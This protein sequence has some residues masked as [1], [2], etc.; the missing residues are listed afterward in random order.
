[1][2]IGWTAGIG[3][4]GI[5]IKL[6]VHKHRPY[7]NHISA[8]VIHKECVA[9]QNSQSGKPSGVTQ[10]Q[11]GP[12]ILP[13]R[14]PVLIGIVRWDGHGPDPLFLQYTAGLDTECVHLL[15]DHMIDMRIGNTV[16]GRENLA[17]QFPGKD[18]HGPTIFID[19]RWTKA[20]R[21][22]KKSLL[23][24]NAAEICAQ[25]FK[26]LP[27]LSC[28]GQKIDPFSLSLKPSHEPLGLLCVPQLTVK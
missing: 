6:R 16:R 23:G 7:L 2:A 20:P 26:Q 21:S 10:R 27:D 15:G 17:G 9:S 12:A 8:F 1:L 28:S 18:D 14:F 25:I 22:L 11:D 5:P 13:L 19:V 4:Q 3:C 24:G